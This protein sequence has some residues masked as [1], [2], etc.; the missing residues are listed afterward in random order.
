M[1]ARLEIAVPG[2]NGR[3]HKIVFRNRL[4]DLGMERAGIADAGRAAVANDVEAEPIE[5]I[6]EAGLLQV[7]GNDT[8]AGREGGFDRRVDR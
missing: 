6:L 2:K 1:D 3:S 7:I 8:G 4:F 5:L